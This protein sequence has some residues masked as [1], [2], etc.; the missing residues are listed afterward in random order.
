MLRPHL[1]K[2]KSAANNISYAVLKKRRQG[3]ALHITSSEARLVLTAAA[4][5][6]AALP[7]AVAPEPVLEQT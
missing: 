6:I 3:A 7:V 5:S 2:V 1:G 4:H